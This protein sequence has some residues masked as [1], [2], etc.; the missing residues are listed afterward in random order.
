MNT[1]DHKSPLLVVGRKRNLAWAA[2][3]S[4]YKS[5]QHLRPLKIV[6]MT[7]CP[8][9]QKQKRTSRSSRAEVLSFISAAAKL[10]RI[11]ITFLTKGDIR[12]AGSTLVVCLWK[13]TSQHKRTSRIGTRSSEA[14]AI[15]YRCPASEPWLPTRTKT[16]CACKKE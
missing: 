14:K 12:R 15:A 5:C 9:Q 4:S 6:P 16:T 10:F 2:H 1:T 13:K 7:D 3:V 8:K 11:R